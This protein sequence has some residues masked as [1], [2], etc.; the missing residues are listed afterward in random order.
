MNLKELKQLKQVKAT[1][2]DKDFI[3]ND[4]IIKNFENQCKQLYSNFI[5]IKSLVKTTI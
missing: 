4:D 3:S 5:I 2:H 1:R